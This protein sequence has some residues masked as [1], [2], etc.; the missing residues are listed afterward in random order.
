MLLVR[1]DG[2]DAHCRRG[3]LLASAAGLL[4]GAG[5]RGMRA[6][7][8]RVL[9]LDQFSQPGGAQ[10]CL[11]DVMAECVS[12]GWQ[13]VLMTPGED[14]AEYTLPLRAYSC[15]RKTLHDAARFSLDVPRM[16]KAVHR[17][18]AELRPHLVYANGPRVLPAVS[19]LPCPV[20]FHAHSC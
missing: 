17:I 19:G 3:Y 18:V 7:S 13:T 8:M 2:A 1:R 5:N 6:G 20:V 15:G 11:R 12:R 14:H 9:F 10:L 16:K 4:L